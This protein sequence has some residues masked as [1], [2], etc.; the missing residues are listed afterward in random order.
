MVLQRVEKT[1]F[2]YCHFGGE[3]VVKKDRSVLYKGGLVDGLVIDQDTAYETFVGEICE[4]LCITPT[5]KLFQYSVKFDKSCLLPLKDQ[6]G[7]N[8]LLYFNE[9]VGYVYVVEAAEVANPALISNRSSNKE[10]PLTS[11]QDTEVEYADRDQ[12]RYSNTESQDQHDEAEYADRDLAGCSDTENHLASDQHGDEQYTN[13]DDNYAHRAQPVSMQCTTSEK[14]PFLLNEWERELIGGV[15]R[16]P[17]KVTAYGV[18]NTNLIRVNTLIDKHEHLVQGQTNLKPSLKTR[19]VAE[20]IKENMKESPDHVSRQ[21]CMDF[22]GDLSVPSTYF[23][24]SRKEQLIHGMKNVAYKLIPSMCQHIMD[25]MPGSI[26]TWSSTEDNQFRQLFVAYGCSIRGFQLGC[27]PLL[28]IDDYHLS[29]PFRGTLWSVTAL[30]AND[31]IYPVAYWIV[32]T[33]NDVDWSWFFE[34]LKLIVGMREIA[35]ISDRN[36]SLL[37]RLNKVFGFE[38]HSYCYRRLKQ[39]FSSYFQ[40]Q[41]NWEQTALQLLDDIAF[42]RLGAEYEK[43]LVTQHR[44]CKEMY[45]WVMA[46]HPE[47]WANAQFKRKRWDKLN[48]DETDVFYSW[49]WKECQ[50]PI[51]EFMKAHQCKL[52]NLLLG[53]QRDV[54]TWKSPVGYKIEQKIR[55]NMSKAESLV[56]SQMSEFVFE[57]ELQSCKF[58]V[59]LSRMDCTCLEWQMTGIPCLHAC[60]ALQHANRDVYEF[61]EKWYHRDTQQT[62]YTEVM[63]DFSTHDMP[64]LRPID[65]KGPQPGFSH[66]GQTESQLKQI[67]QI[68]FKKSTCCSC[69]NKSGHNRKTCKSTLQE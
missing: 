2:C 4:Q 66:K 49:M 30:D 17:W 56:G 5:G 33:D 21:T 22:L 9:G 43:A 63:P 35:I 47:H 36:Q 37:N 24:S 20:M 64:I 45:E 42:A 55:E 69:C 34:K 67:S 59:D 52:S 41:S 58:K 68:K 57:F 40:L 60:S 25:V 50:K 15:D 1:L 54:M 14:S 8:N 13:A 3:L 18:R 65:S 46:N 53:R 48:A 7:L 19:L 31:G 26:A 38:T 23:Y 61:V 11:D 32:A 12:V 16:C 28:F 62:L 51:L 6:N 44:Y 27:R 29:I 10:S 39:S